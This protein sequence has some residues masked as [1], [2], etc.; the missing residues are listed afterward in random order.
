LR[1]AGT[2]HPIAYLI[3]RL[4]QFI[5]GIETVNAVWKTGNGELHTEN[6]VISKSDT[7]GKLNIQKWRSKNVQYE[8][9]KTFDP[10]NST[11]STT[12][13]LELSDENEL[14]VL[15][16]Y[17]NSTT[18]NSKDIIA[19]HFP[20][21]LFLGNLNM[22]FSG[23]STKEKSILSNILSSVLYA[24]H[25][26][27][28]K[29]HKLLKQIETHQSQ[30]SQKIAQLSSNLKQSEHLYTSALKIIV[31]D[32]VKVFE[33]N[34]DKSIS[35]ENEVILRLAKERIS[36]DQI[37]EILENAIHVAYN[38]SISSNELVI[39]N[40]LIHINDFKSS[41]KHLEV[42]SEH[43]KVKLLL[44]RYES[45]AENARNNGHNVN[46]KNV[47]RHLEPPVTPPAITDA[48]K[49]NEKKIHYYLEKYPNHWKLIR[50]NLR[51]LQ[52]I[53]DELSRSYRGVG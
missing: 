10:L 23:L 17:F 11:S 15:L 26:R 33:E 22:T 35:V 2:Y 29:E 41:E 45:A 28:L 4:D 12:R 7:S 39:N 52:I 21:H 34:L 19:I 37:T 36:K 20:Q 16:I 3:E 14:N 5:P 6:G 31:H 30:Q 27:C 42:N 44:D 48:I 47:A 40:D 18:D 24:E 46:G 50:S 13:Q 51:P 49:K 38:L 43:D 53:D 25:E 32:I 8:W 1:L 9:L